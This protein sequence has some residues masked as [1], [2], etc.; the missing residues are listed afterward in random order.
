M[1]AAGVSQE[2]RMA[3]QGNEDGVLKEGNIIII[4]RGK[5]LKEEKAAREGCMKERET[6]RERKTSREGNVKG[7]KTPREGRC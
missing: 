4:E 6:L 7:R 3:R 2:R 1:R 5:C